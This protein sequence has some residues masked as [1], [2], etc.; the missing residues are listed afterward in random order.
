M[1]GR[2]A[3]DSLQLSPQV[4]K[5]S[6]LK[7]F[8]GALTPVKG[9]GNLPDALLLH[10]AQANHARLR[11]RKPVHQLKEDDVPL[12]LLRIRRLGLRN[13][14]PGLPAYALV[15]VRHSARRNP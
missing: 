1:S 2:S 11:I 4:L 14:I 13:R 15:V 6:K 3:M 7:L 8:D 12:D 5:G 9:P 10:E